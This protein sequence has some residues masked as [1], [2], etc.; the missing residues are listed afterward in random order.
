MIINFFL[1][2]A[3]PSAAAQKAT[4]AQRNSIQEAPFVDWTTSDSG[5]RAAQQAGS[6]CLSPVALISIGALLLVLLLAVLVVLVKLGRKSGSS[7]EH[8]FYSH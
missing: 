1:L 7:M 5:R 6:V 4:P 2:C 3:E 8:S